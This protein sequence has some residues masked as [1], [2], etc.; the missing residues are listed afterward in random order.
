MGNLLWR[1][2]SEGVGTI[3]VLDWATVGVGVPVHDIGQLMI[4]DVPI[5]TRRICEHAVLAKYYSALVA[6]GIKSYSFET[7]RRDYIFGI[8]L[9]CLLFLFCSYTVLSQVHVEV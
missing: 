5:A 6:G 3:K 9:A 1:E 2:T 4:M 8:V 7:L